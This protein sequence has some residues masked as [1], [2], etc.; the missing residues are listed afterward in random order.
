MHERLR[1]ELLQRRAAERRVRGVPHADVRTCRS[2]L[3]HERRLQGRRAVHDD[4][5]L[6][7]QVGPQLAQQLARTARGAAHTKKMARTR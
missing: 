3:V 7:L 2:R 4:E 6:Q 5:R 1:C